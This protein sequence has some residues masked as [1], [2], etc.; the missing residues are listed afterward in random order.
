MVE[1]DLIEGNIAVDSTL[2]IVPQSEQ[3]EGPAGKW[4]G[5][6]EGAVHRIVGK[7][8]MFDYEFD[9]DPKNP[10]TFKMTPKGY[11]HESGSGTVKDKKTGDT[12]VLKK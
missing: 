5:K 7:V 11:K 4:D 2:E 3:H 6:G 9:P 12:Y 10:L 8:T 1:W